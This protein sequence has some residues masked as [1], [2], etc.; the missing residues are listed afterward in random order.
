MSDFAKNLRA[1]RKSHG[2]SQVQLAQVLHYGYTAISNYESGR[3]EPSLDD[4]IRLADFFDIS[5]DALLG[6]EYLLQDM[7]IYWKFSLLSAKEKEKLL[8]L[9][10]LFL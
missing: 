7:E 4:L 5:T 6:R 9:I 10:E 3:N 1:L 8:R 2:V